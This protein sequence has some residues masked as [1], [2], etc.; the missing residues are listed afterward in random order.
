MSDLLTEITSLH[1]L[2]PLSHSLDVISPTTG[3]PMNYDCSQTIGSLGADTVYVTIKRNSKPELMT[4]E[5]V[6]PVAQDQHFL[7]VS[8]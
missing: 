4:Q 3:N 6:R 8:K 1:D 5:D 2:N 7:A